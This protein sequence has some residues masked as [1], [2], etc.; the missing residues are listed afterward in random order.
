MWKDPIVEEV[1]H[2]RMKLSAKFGHDV[3]AICANAREREKRSDRRVVT[4]R[5]KRPQ[6]AHKARARSG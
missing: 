4:R 3:D 6:T 1:H 5:P 2:V